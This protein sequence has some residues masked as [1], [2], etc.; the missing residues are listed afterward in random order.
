M[1]GISGNNWNWC[2]W[3]KAYKAVGEALNTLG[4]TPAPETIDALLRH[5]ARIHVASGS[6]P[7]NDWHLQKSIRSNIEAERT[8]QGRK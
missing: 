5:A 3:E 1:F 8:E 7:E 6:V 4:P 2:A